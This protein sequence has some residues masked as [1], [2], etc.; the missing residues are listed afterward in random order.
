M[1]EYNK[2][3]NQILS[4]VNEQFRK[5]EFQDGLME[6]IKTFS[7]IANLHKNMYEEMKK[8]GYTEKQSFEFASEYVLRSLRL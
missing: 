7:S 2:R 3:K 5:K 6:V 1:D 4:K 8:Q